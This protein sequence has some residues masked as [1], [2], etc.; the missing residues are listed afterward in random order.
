MTTENNKSN[1][2]DSLKINQIATWY[3]NHRKNANIILI[4]LIVAV[5]GLIYY[6]KCINRHRN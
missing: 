4:A 5:A 1:W 3:E 6:Q 2:Q